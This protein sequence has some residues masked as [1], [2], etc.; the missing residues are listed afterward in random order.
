M[1]TFTIGMFT[2]HDYYGEPIET[3]LVHVSTDQTDQA[4]LSELRH[5]AQGKLHSMAK[6]MPHDYWRKRNERP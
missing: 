5:I 4:I 1:N 6:R 2:D 3:T